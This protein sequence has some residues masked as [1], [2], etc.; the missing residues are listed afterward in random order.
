MTI[1]RDDD[2]YVWLQ[3]KAV[4]CAHDEELQEYILG[5]AKN[6]KTALQSQLRRIMGN[7][8]KWNCQ[9]RQR[10]NSWTRSLKNAY[11]EIEDIFLQ[12]PSLRRFALELDEAQIKMIYN[13]AVRIAVDEMK[14]NE[15]Q[16]PEN[17]CPWT[18][19]QLLDYGKLD[20]LIS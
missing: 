8:I 9:P 11:E 15:Y 1:T 19:E 3:A 10:S 2:E 4:E 17:T 12:S 6:E 5:M 13:R 7:L 14:A 20:A 16:K 18:I